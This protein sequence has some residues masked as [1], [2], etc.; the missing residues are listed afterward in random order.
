MND[1]FFSLPKMGR[2]SEGLIDNRAATQTPCE[3][4]H[5][6]SNHL[7]FFYLFKIFLGNCIFFLT[8]IF[9]F[10]KMV[11]YYHYKTES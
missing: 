10:N 5:Y 2:V 11:I 9:I 7:Y 3:S 1:G 4:N 8:Q 6:K